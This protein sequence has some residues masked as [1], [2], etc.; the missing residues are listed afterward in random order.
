MGGTR[1]K[2]A[3]VGDGKILAQSV[4]PTNAEEKT[5]TRMKRVKNELSTLSSGFEVS[6]IRKI[7]VA[8]AG[9]VNPRENKIITSNGKYYD[10]A[11]FDLSKWCLN[12]LKAELTLEN[13]ANAAL[14]GETAYGAGKGAKD[15]VIMVLGTGVGTAAMMNGQLVRGR[16]FQAGCLGGHFPIEVGGRRCGCGNF[17]CVEA[18]ASGWALPYIAREDKDF[19]KSGLSA[20][21]RIDFEALEKWY[22]KGDALAVKSVNRFA[23]CWSAG[24]A[25]LIH[26]YDPETV[27]LSGG[28]MK[29]GALLGLIEKRVKESVW[30]P[31]GEV[32]ITLAKEPEQSALLGLHRLMEEGH[33]NE[34]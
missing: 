1:I 4:I 8:F 19:L 29:F 15:A 26:A 32:E 24:I 12:E 5:E 22:T 16:H 23:D 33:N 31:W 13:D 34:L 2:S 3:V 9:I 11:E 6:E 10:A 14:V 7:G 30:T 18:N 27:I 21:E 20:E 25:G 28:V 17:G